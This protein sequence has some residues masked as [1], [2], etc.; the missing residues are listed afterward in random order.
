MPMAQDKVRGYYHYNLYYRLHL[1]VL[2]NEQEAVRAGDEADQFP[3]SHVKC[4]KSN[5]LIGGHKRSA[6]SATCKPHRCQL[7]G[8]SRK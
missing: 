3:Q 4:Q 6:T 2:G 7:D 8:A 5:I 1:V